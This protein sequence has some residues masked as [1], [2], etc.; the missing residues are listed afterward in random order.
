[1]T[2][3]T[4]VARS[5]A[6]PTRR[7]RTASAS[8]ARKCGSSWSSASTIARLAAEHF[9]PAWPKAERTRSLIAR[10][11]SAAPVMTMAFLPLVSASSRSDGFQSRNSRAVS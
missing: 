3:P 2:G 10:S 5:V 11:T 9:W 4:I 8:R 7:L 1:M 6:G